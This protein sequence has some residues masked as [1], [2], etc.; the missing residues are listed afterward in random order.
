MRKEKGQIAKP[1]ANAAEQ[2]LGHSAAQG[3]IRSAGQRFVRSAGQRSR[4]VGGRFLV[5]ALGAALLFS[6]RKELSVEKM[7]GLSGDFR[8]QINGA[9]WIAADTAKGAYQLSGLTNITGIS[10]DHKQ[11]SITLTDTV[12]GTYTLDQSSSSL[13]AYADNDSSDIY[14][15]STN[16]G[17]DTSQAGGV[18]IL[19]EVDRVNKTLSGTFSFKVY[20]D[21]DGHQKV[22]RSGVFYKL[23]YVNTLPPNKNGDTMSAKISGNSWI[24]QSISTQSIGGQIAI[25]GSLISGLQNIGLIMPTDITPGTYDLDLV[26][27]NYIG[28]YNPTPNVAL[29]SYKGTLTILQNNTRIQRIRGNFQFQATDPLSGLG[30]VQTPITNGYFAVSYGP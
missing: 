23:S 28:L 15:F 4:F 11:L 30:S 9:Q 22:I 24:A 5:I 20:R 8:A 14:A 18:V 29:A 25:S 16:Q 26:G 17:S 3:F 21:I 6:C 10:P 12:P 2:G 1:T 19:T 13:A 7:A 27:L